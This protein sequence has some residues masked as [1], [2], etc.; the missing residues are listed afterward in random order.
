MVVKEIALNVTLLW[1]TEK[2]KF[3]MKLDVHVVQSAP[4]AASSLTDVPEYKRGQSN[5]G[6]FIVPVRS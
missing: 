3:M 2:R 5:F 1:P 6:W 4:L